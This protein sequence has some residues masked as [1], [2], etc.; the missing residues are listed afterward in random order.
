MEDGGVAAGLGGLGDGRDLE[1]ELSGD[2]IGM[3]GR[4]GQ[5]AADDLA[6]QEY[7]VTG[8]NSGDV[9]GEDVAGE[10]WDEDRRRVDPVGWIPSGGMVTVAPSR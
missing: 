3:V 7:Q 8:F 4:S 1:G 6:A 2:R 9:D 5:H 10:P